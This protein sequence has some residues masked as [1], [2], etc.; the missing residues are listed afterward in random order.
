MI[1]HS[2]PSAD[3]PASLVPAG[4]SA[5]SRPEAVW[6]HGLR[7]RGIARLA[8]IV[9]GLCCVASAGGATVVTKIGDR[10]VDPR[11]MT[12]SLDAPYGFMINGGVSGNDVVTSS[13]GW[14]YSAYYVRNGTPGSTYHVAVARRRIPSRDGSAGLWEVADLR[15]STFTRGLSGGM[16]WD[17]HNVVSLGIDEPTGSLHLGWDVHNH[18]LLYR[19]T[20]AGTVSGTP[21]PWTSSLF[22]PVTSVLGTETVTAAAY[23]NFIQDE[24]GGLDLVHRVGGSGNGSWIIRR[25]N[26]GT[27]SWEPGFQFDDGR[28]GTYIPLGSTRRNAYPNGYSYGHDGRLHSTFVWREPVALGG[29]GTNHD[30]C[31]AYSDDDGD[32]WH[33]NAG[34][35]IASRTAG[36][37]ITVESPGLVVWPLPQGSGLMNT[38]GQ[39]VDGAGRIHSVMWH[40]DPALAP[41]PIPTFDPVV[42][43]TYHYWRDSGGHW[44]RGRLPVDPTWARPRLYFDADDN[45]I[46]VFGGG[47]L[48]V[49][50]ATRASDWSDWQ[51]V[52]VEPDYGSDAAADRKLLLE[53]GVL[54]LVMQ[55]PPTLSLESTEIRSLDFAVTFSPATRTT[56]GD[57]TWDSAASWDGGVPGSGNVAVVN[58]GRSAGIGHEVGQVDFAGLVLG[59]SAGPGSLTVE[60]GSVTIAHDVRIGTAPGGAG[61]LRVREGR[62]EAGRLIVG[63]WSDDHRGGGRGVVD[64]IGGTLSTREIQ[65]GVGGRSS[66]G[67]SLMRV[68][69]GSLHVAGDVMLGDFGNPVGLELTGGDVRVEGDMG[70]GPNAPGLGTLAIDGGALDMTG[71]AIV[72]DTLTIGH[73]RLSNASRV[74]AR[75]IMLRPAAG[76]FRSDG[77]ADLAGLSSTDGLWRIG[78]PA[79]GGSGTLVVAG[80]VELATTDALARHA[81][82]VVHGGRFAVATGSPA[83]VG[84][85]VVDASGRVELQ[86]HRL[87]IAGGVDPTA[88]RADLIRGR[89]NGNWSGDSGIVSSLAAESGGTLA[90]GYLVAADGSAII[91]VVAPGDVDLN[92]R[93]DSFDLVAI[94][95]SGRYG[96]GLT[97]EWSQGDVTYD[98]VTNVFDLVSI[99]TAGAYAIA[100][101]G[102]GTVTSATVPEP[103]ALLLLTLAGVAAFSLQRRGIHRRGESFSARR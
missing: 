4:S 85:L 47:A 77:S 65:I 70:P 60:H 26:P 12:L 93:V 59:D 53:E 81:V 56:F 54:S 25:F 96:T 32:T 27:A 20:A 95:A 80:S 67:G 75:E 87:A 74:S 76:V 8:G 38:Q 29:D 51:R 6:H 17:S 45:A 52:H 58:R 64:L 50:A 72:V 39:A 83:A 98:G 84:G 101:S 41:S 88:L 89:A 34:D 68:A 31:Y 40:R 100:H 11:G 24:A 28:A 21:P 61:T 15:D 44:R 2:L 35:V 63:S 10:L 30:L 13:R 7:G 79:L 1:D 94:N 78:S 55:R 19:S 36:T 86:E 33:N 73:G 42:S 99:A 69:G 49:F 62:L 48:Q 97:A 16:P 71:N 103:R 14:Q 22:N 102:S 18:R 37:R 43:S 57:G 90:I 92:G 91:G 9:G 23:P 66:S 46:A 5:L 82:H 3:P